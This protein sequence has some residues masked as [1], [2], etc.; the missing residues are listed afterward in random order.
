M[1][2]DPLSAAA[3]VVSAGAALYGQHSANRANRQLAGRQMDFQERMSNTAVQR[4]VAD[5]RAAGLNPMLAY[6]GAASSPEG[7]LPRMES[8]LGAGVEGAV[9]GVTAVSAARQAQAQTDLI[10][11]QTELLGA[12][13]DE[14][15]SRI[16][17]Q[18]ASAE[19]SRAGAEFA[20]AQIPKIRE[21]ILHIRSQADL[22]RVEAKW[23]S[24]DLE[25]KKMM[26][27]HIRSIMASEDFL[28]QFEVPGAR[29]KAEASRIWEWYEQNVKP[30][31]PFL[32]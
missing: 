25:Q 8:E 18:T 4:R 21:E 13:K 16:G 1:P 3:G 22:A 27:P 29:N 15:Y 30:L 10:R 7:A 28:K 20:R 6:S 23:K 24:F 14:I 2:F 26:A 5:L 17:Q 32:K 12:Q 31:L 19:A 9:K 11:G